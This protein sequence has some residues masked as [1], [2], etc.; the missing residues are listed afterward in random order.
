MKIWIDADACP[1]E[2]KQ[3]VFRASARRGFDV[4]LV[5]NQRIG[6]PANLKR[7]QSIIVP[8]GANEADKYIART[9]VPGDIAIT[10]DLPLAAELVELGICAID[11]RGAEYTA[12]TVRSRLSM[13]DFMDNLRG[14]GVTT[15]GAAPFNELD[16]KAFAAALDRRLTAYERNKNNA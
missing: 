5:A 15:G 2:V 12:D 11:P 10:A 16:K 6:F 7:V 13:R 8:H 14:S 1:G 3:I 4:M 9:A